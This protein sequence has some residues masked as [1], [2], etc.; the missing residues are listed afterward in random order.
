MADLTHL[1]GGPIKAGSDP[2]PAPAEHQLIDAIRDAGLE[3]PDSIILDGKLHRFRSGGKGHGKGGDKPGW[4][5]AFADGIPAGRFG[6]WRSGIEQSWRADVGRQYTPA[7]EMAFARR[8]AEASAVREA[9]R[10]K[11]REAV[12]ETVESIWAACTAAAPDHPYLARKGVKTHGSRVTGDGRLVVPMYAPDGHLSSLQYIS[13]DGTKLYHAGG[14]TGGCSWVV[15][16]PDQP[17]TYIAEGFA[18]AATVAEASGGHCVVA[19]SASNLPV[20][21]GQIRESKGQGHRIVVVADRDASGTG[22]KY[23]DQCAAKYGCDVILPPCDGDV[24]DYAKAGGD[25]R[26]LLQPPPQAEW[27]I[28]VDQFCAKPAPLSWLIKGWLPD[29]GLA[30][31]HGPSG[32]G[33]TFAILDWCLRIAGR[34]ADWQGCKVNSKGSIIYLA[35]EGHHGLKSRIAAW[36]QYNQQGDKLD[37]YISASGCDL[38]TPAGFTKTLQAI[39]AVGAKPCLIVVDTL[40]RH[41][42]G[43]EN[44]AQDA[45]TMLDA[46][47][48]LQ[49]EFGCAVILIHHTGVSEEAQHRARG[50]SAWRGALDVE[51][52]LQ[53]GR[54]GAVAIIQRKMKDAELRPPLHATLH[55]I[56]IEGWT[57]ED[58]DAVTSAVMIATDAPETEPKDDKLG[59]HRR[60]FEDA[61]SASGHELDP[62]G[63]PYLTRAA[64][65]AYLTSPAVELTEASAKAETKP[66]NENRCVGALTK[67]RAIEQTAHGWSITDSVW[68]SAI[69][70]LNE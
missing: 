31:L 70:M 57:D 35:G 22:Q 30:M 45:K 40:H 46:C 25:V 42:Y 39:R 5:I 47:N 17:M 4:Y 21:A 59:K 34:Q 69:K 23:A 44:S 56:E 52:S 49:S 14:Q 62:N 65:M 16:T 51:I 3:P 33:K 38:N 63:R 58:G 37:M 12:A 19:Y 20:V 6:C 43:D 66:A 24:N 36:K 13:A 48:A 55:K 64:L 27:L 32:C 10:A 29:S 68:A 1:F 2:I 15:G 26:A 60:R 41:L 61:W 9:E 67:A 7:D 50:S 53:P 11:L 18:T 8:M 54:E 28:P